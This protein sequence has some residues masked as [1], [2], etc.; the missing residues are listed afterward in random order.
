MPSLISAAGRR[1]KQLEFI[2]TWRAVASHGSSCYGGGHQHAT[3]SVLNSLAALESL[4]APTHAPPPCQPQG[5]AAARLASQI[6]R[7]LTAD[8]H[9]VPLRPS[10]RSAGQRRITKQ[11]HSLAASIHTVFHHELNAQLQSRRCHLVNSLAASIQTASH[12]VCALFLPL[13]G[14]RNT[15]LPAEEGNIRIGKFS[16]RSWVV[17]KRRLALE[18]PQEDNLACTHANRSDKTSTQ[19]VCSAVVVGSRVH[20][21]VPL[22]TAHIACCAIGQATSSRRTGRV[23]L[24]G[25]ERTERL[26]RRES[27]RHRQ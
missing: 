13:K 10:S 14:R 6:Q 3:G 23:H 18:G 26:E 22:R 5:E 8:P 11:A 16:R 27:A 2:N 1:D 9:R 25:V 17:V 19:Q 7:Q 20:V 21:Q 15:I 24:R 12:T 4:A